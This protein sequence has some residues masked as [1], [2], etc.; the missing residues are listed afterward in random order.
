MILDSSNN[1][2]C[3]QILKEIKYQG[4]EIIK[5]LEGEKMLLLKGEREKKNENRKKV[6]DRRN[7]T[8]VFA[9]TNLL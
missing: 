7:I 6:R 3:D 5:M 2:K 8:V 1:V 9:S 4:D